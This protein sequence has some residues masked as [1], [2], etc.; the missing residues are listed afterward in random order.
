MKK[1]L[2]TGGAG[3][4]GIHI[5]LLL[6]EN[7]IEVVIIDSLCTSN[8]KSI[9]RLFEYKKIA[10]ISLKFYKGDIRDLDFLRNVFSDS[11]NSGIPI[12]SV[13]HVAGLKSVF[14]SISFPAVYWDVNVLGTFQILRIMK[15]FNCNNFVF[16]S[17]ATIYNLDQKSPIEEDAQIA[18]TNPY[19]NTKATV[20][21]IL[22]DYANN[23][24]EKWNIISLRYFN[25]IGAHPS[26]LFGESPLKT[27]S[28]LFP[29]LCQVASLKREKLSIYGKNWPTNDGTCIRD[30]IHIMDLADSHI[31]SLNYL[32]DNKTKENSFIAINIGTGKGTSVLELV[33]TFEKVNKININ[34]HFVKRRIGDKAVV[35]ANAKMAKKILKWE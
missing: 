16:S 34:K 31:A 7:D 29:Y 32:D 20:E 19:G 33:Q 22:Q 18:P 11:K 2:V 3:Y 24:S 27:P 5:S 10:N 8:F 26:G 12:D 17:S 21:N 14:D 13:I 9:K 6:L 15:E 23:N 30:F 1:V 25:P 28:N 4:I 35:Y